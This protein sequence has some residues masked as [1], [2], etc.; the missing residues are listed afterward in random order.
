MFKKDNLE[1]PTDKV[2]TVIGKDTS[3]SGTINGNGLIRIDGSAE[4]NINNQGDVIVGEGGSVAVDLKAR[5]VT[6]AGHYEGTL[7]AEGRLELKKTGTAIGTFKINGLLVEEGAV[8]A[9]NTE[10]PDAEAKETGKK[11]SVFR[12]ADKGSSAKEHEAKDKEKQASA[13]SESSS[14][15]KAF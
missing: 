3:F 15:D 1:T 8:L 5:N 6:I 14:K 11:D 13:F 10:M 4:G 7:E 2:N 9:G 12:K